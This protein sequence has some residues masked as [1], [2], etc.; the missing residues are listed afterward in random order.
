M[1][2]TPQMPRGP[3]SPR[4]P[5]ARGHMVAIALL[6]LG[7]IV[8][9][10]AIAL[11]VGFR[12][13]SRNMQLQVKEGADKKKSASIK[14]PFASFEARQDVDEA[15]LGLPIY[16]GATRV[17]DKDAATVNMEFGGEEGVRIVAAKF[18]TPDRVE[19]VSAFYRDRLGG[20]VT[21]YTEKD[22]WDK[23]VFEIKK[24]DNAKVVSLMRRSDGT[25]IELVR[26]DHQKTDVN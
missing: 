13:L 22:S 7:L 15:S 5:Q 12:Y 25:L 11:W 2:V 26:V 3:E 1:S 16:P 9:V 18:D 10:S 24:G 4:P 21:K 19:K 6:V 17:K 23:T 20:R 8:T 14:L